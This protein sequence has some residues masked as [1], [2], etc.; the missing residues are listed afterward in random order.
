M[1]AE[2]PGLSAPRHRGAVDARE[3]GA[4]AAPRRWSRPV[5]AWHTW[6]DGLG[7]HEVRKTCGGREAS[8]NKA[9]VIQYRCLAPVRGQT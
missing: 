7:R 5:E 8:E 9:G 1:R 3:T 4:S 2:I 6:P